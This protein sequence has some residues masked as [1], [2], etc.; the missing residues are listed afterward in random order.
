MK[1]KNDFVVKE[2]SDSIVVI[3]VGSQ[4]M[5]FN[6]MIKVNETGSF[7]FNLLKNNVTEEELVKSLISEY[8]V[9]ENIAKQDVAKFLKKLEDAGVIE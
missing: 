2:I 6:G 8:D 1:I 7:L 4:V 9:S 3:P 5:D